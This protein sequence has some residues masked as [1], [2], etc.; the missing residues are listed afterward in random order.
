M[1]DTQQTA[2]NA[3]DASHDDGKKQASMYVPR[4]TRQIQQQSNVHRSAKGVGT[5][6]FDNN[7]EPCIKEIMRQCILDATASNRCTLKESHLVNAYETV[8]N[9]QG[10]ETTRGPSGEL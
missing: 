5:S 9:G 4:N 6:I 3:C 10:L 2:K 7:V 8:F 1:K